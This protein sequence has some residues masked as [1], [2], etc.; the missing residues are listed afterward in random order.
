MTA[1]LTRIARALNSEWLEAL[2]NEA[3]ECTTRRSRTVW[4][5]GG[6]RFLAATASALRPGDADLQCG[7]RGGAGARTPRKQL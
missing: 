6:T 3:G 4:L 2:A 1:L 5:L 7:G